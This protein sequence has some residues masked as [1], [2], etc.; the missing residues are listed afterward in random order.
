[1]FWT[2]VI[3]LLLLVLIIWAVRTRVKLK[4]RYRAEG[5]ESTVSSPA[6]VAL[7]ELI[8]IAGGIYLSLILAVS[9][10]ELKVPDTVSI[11]SMTLDPLAM[12]AIIVALLQPLFLVL[13]YRLFGR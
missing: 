13:Y 2:V 3:I 12:I 11:M 6:S 7:G 4:R 1:M 9:F 10:L 5:I 8:A